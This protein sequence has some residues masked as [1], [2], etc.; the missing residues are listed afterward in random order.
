[1]VNSSLIFFSLVRNANL[2]I[3]KTLVSGKNSKMSTNH[4]ARTSCWWVL[5]CA[6]HL[7]FVHLPNWNFSLHLPPLWRPRICVV[8]HFQRFIFSSLP[9]S[10]TE[11]V[12]QESTFTFKFTLRAIYEVN[13]TA[14]YLKRCWPTTDNDAILALYLIYTHYLTLSEFYRYFNQLIHQTIDP[15]IHW[16]INPLMHWSIHWSINRSIS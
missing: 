13:G 8:D 2:L 15:S 9:T 3:V 6:P 10:P 5:A 14:Q 4:C 12:K 7:R 1:M 11:I 16:S